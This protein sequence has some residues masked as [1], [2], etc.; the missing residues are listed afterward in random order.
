MFIGSPFHQNLPGLPKKNMFSYS[1]A[2]LPSSPIAIFFFE[3]LFTADVVKNEK[4][5]KQTSSNVGV[6]KGPVPRG[7]PGREDNTAA[8][9]VVSSR[10]RRSTDPSRVHQSRADVTSDL[11][12]PRPPPNRMRARVIIIIII[13]IA[14]RENYLV[15]HASAPGAFIKTLF[16]IIRSF[17]T[18][19]RANGRRCA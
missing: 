1:S 11:I 3:C 8:S 7:R 13:I 14:A 19:M 10:R 4:K 16:P 15:R 2:P 17:E 6:G 5:M 9:L 12:T 18:R